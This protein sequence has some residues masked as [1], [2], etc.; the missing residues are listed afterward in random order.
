M[1]KVGNISHRHEMLQQS[2]LFCEIFDVWGIDFM[3]PFP[4]SYGF[5]YILLA[6][7]YVS[8]WVEAKATRTDDAKVVVDFVRSHIFCRFGVPR[9]IISGQGTHFCNRQMKA[10]MAIYGVMHKVYTPY[11]P[12]TNGQAEISNREIKQIL[13]KTINVDRKDWS[14]RLDDALWAYR[15]AYKTP[16]GMSPYR[17]VFGK[18]CLLILQSFPIFLPLII[19]AKSPYLHHIVPVSYHVSRHQRC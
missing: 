4:S 18:A 9:A 6:V 19:F 3:G 17:I 12:Q 2:M 14:I 5:V 15:T 13:T 10:L 8:K 1:T 7:V 16:I 11:H